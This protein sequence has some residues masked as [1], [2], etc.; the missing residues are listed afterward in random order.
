MNR[1]IWGEIYIDEQGKA[2]LDCHIHNS[3]GFDEAQGALLKFIELLQDQ[4]E[5]REECP[6][7]ISEEAGRRAA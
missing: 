5:R 4:I 3:V 2:N 6:L 7:Y 1:K